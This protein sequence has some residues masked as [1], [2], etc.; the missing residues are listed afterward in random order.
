M[1]P[2]VQKYIKQYG[3]N[4]PTKV[5]QQYVVVWQCWILLNLMQYRAQSFPTWRKLCHFKKIMDVSYTDATKLKDLVKVSIC[6][7]PSHDSDLLTRTIT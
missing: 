3:R 6:I 2:A 7:H 4:G 5:D 1:W